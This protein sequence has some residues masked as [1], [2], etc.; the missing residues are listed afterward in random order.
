[1]F[2]AQKSLAKC[3]HRNPH[4]LILVKEAGDVED[5]I[6]A[7]VQEF[8]V[9]YSQF[10]QL[11][12]DVVANY[13]FA[14]TDFEDGSADLV[15]VGSFFLG[16]SLDEV[17]LALA[18]GLGGVYQ[19]DLGVKDTLAQLVDDDDTADAFGAVASALLHVSLDVNAKEVG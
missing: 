18:F 1:M 11:L 14:E 4:F 15:D 16:L 8:G 2:E 3:V 12:E 6:L 17:G 19:L 7:I 10:L 5:G 13:L 9:V